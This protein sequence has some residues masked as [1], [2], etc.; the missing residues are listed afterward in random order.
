[1]GRTFAALR[2]YLHGNEVQCLRF[3]I[4]QLRSTLSFAE[5]VHAEMVDIEGVETGVCLQLTVF[6]KRWK[7]GWRRTGEVKDV[8]DYDSI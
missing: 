7:S 6:A 8:T 2:K 4:D 3:S 1:M 5:S